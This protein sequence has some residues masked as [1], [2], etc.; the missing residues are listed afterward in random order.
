MTSIITKL[1]V[2]FFGIGY[3][4]ICPGTIASVATLP[5][6]IL[7]IFM[8]NYFNVKIP[9]ISITLIISGIYMV[10]YSY[11]R[12]Y[13]TKNNLDDPSEVV[14]DEV[15]GQLLSFFISLF[16]IYFIRDMNLQAITS[17]NRILFCLLLMILPIVLFRLFDI[18]KPW[19]I[20]EIDSNMK[21]AYG[22][23][24][25]DIFAGIFAGVLNIILTVSAIKFFLL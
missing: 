12:K 25:D 20:G 2:T 7:I 3:S 15:V 17:N 21:N 1:V 6:W 9:V 10:G 11:T 16:F 14:I 5:L 22:I 13:I 8:V 18:T 4:P 23:M 19:I 24:L